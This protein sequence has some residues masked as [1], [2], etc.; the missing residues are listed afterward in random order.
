[1]PS[2]TNEAVSPSVDASTAFGT[3]KFVS[4][5]NAKS[6]EDAMNTTW[7]HSAST[8]TDTVRTKQGDGCTADDGSASG[9]TMRATDDVHSSATAVTDAAPAGAKEDGSRDD[10]T[11]DERLAQEPCMGIDGGRGAVVITCPPQAD[12]EAAAVANASQTFTTRQAEASSEH[13]E[14]GAALEGPCDANEAGVGSSCNGEAIGPIADEQHSHDGAPDGQSVGELE[15]VAPEPEASR[16]APRQTASAVSS[17]VGELSLA[18]DGQ[19]STLGSSSMTGKGRVSI[20]DTDTDS[21]NSTEYWDSD[22]EVDSAN[23]GGEAGADGQLDSEAAADLADEDA[24][25]D[26]SGK[27]V[28]GSDLKSEHSSTDEKS[29]HAVGKGDT[30]PL[31]QSSAS[32]SPS[33]ASC[34][35]P[36]PGLL[37]RTDTE[38]QEKPPCC[39]TAVDGYRPI[40]EWIGGQIYHAFEWAGSTSRWWNRV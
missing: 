1:M 22:P 39:R 37:K 15:K 24:T 13:G 19:N 25:S 7:S 38:D 29:V 30:K 33:E 34:D 12:T 31:L 2:D 18:E 14:N 8:K 11:Q 5:E 10:G 9:T 4:N 23:A 27:S 28:D 17:P 32:K 3:A 6:L 35:D 40:G 21:A 36:K 16:K 20:A 26:N